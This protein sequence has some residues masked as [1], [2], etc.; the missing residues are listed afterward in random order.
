VLATPSGTRDQFH[1]AVVET[2]EEALQFFEGY[3]AR[4]DVASDI[5]LDDDSLAPA[6]LMVHAAALKV[7][8]AEAVSMYRATLSTFLGELHKG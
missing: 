5:P 1:I 8:V 3:D 7:R 6:E 4:F 2:L